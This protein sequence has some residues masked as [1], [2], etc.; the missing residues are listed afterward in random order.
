MKTSSFFALLFERGSEHIDAVEGRG[1]RNPFTST[2]RHKDV[3]SRRVVKFSKGMATSAQD[4]CV[5]TRDAA[6]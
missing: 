5:E 2:L 3:L 4:W 6:V 1:R